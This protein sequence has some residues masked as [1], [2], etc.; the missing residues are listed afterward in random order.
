MNEISE[1]TKNKI[2]Y[3]LFSCLFTIHV[4][5]WMVIYYLP[6]DDINTYLVRY[7][8]I[9]SWIMIVFLFIMLIIL[10]FNEIQNDH[11]L[12]IMTII[13]FLLIS[14]FSDKI[15]ILWSKA[16]I[17][18]LDHPISSLLFLQLIIQILLPIIGYLPTQKN[19]YNIIY[20]IIWFCYT[21]S[22]LIS[23]IMIEK[24]FQNE[25]STR[26]ITV[27]KFN[28]WP[29]LIIYVQIAFYVYLTITKILSFKYES[30]GLKY[31]YKG[32]VVMFIIS[33]I[34]ITFLQCIRINRSIY[35]RNT[36]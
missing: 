25:F 19:L 6:V 11:I 32:F 31:A 9:P 20:N 5:S 34:L 24:I 15:Y 12:F 16:D 29:M 35:I 10:L 3:I 21:I 33:T 14:I 7:M 2:Y 22:I 28:I 27:P 8:N 17:Q 18:L 1:H 13:S 4:I 23:N 30:I 26:Y 36:N